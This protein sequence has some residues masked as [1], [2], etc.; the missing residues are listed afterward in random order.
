MDTTTNQKLMGTTKGVQGK[1]FDRGGA[2]GGCNP[3]VLAAID[4]ET[5]EQNKINQ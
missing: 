3:I 5:M 1:R 4:V 2:Q